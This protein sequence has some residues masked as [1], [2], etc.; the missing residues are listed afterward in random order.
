MLSGGGHSIYPGMLFW[1]RSLFTLAPIADIQLNNVATKNTTLRLQKKK[2]GI[3]T[4]HLGY[5]LFLLLVTTCSKL[6][7]LHFPST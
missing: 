1:V 6:Q 4:L 2:G 3:F 5:R 7:K